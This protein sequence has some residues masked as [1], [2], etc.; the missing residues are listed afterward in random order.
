MLK[1]IMVNHKDFK[2]GEIR[3]LLSLL[4]I[5]RATSDSEWKNI[6]YTLYDINRYDLFLEFSQ[7]SPVKRSEQQIKEQFYNNLTQH[8]ISV[9]NLRK[10]L[11]QDIGTEEY[12]KLKNK[13]N[14]GRNHNKMRVIPLTEID[15]TI[16]MNFN[17]EYCFNDFL[18]EITDAQVE[19]I[20]LYITK[21]RQVIAYIAQI[22]GSVFIIKLRDI[23]NYIKYD[24][25]KCNDVYNDVSNLKHNFKVLYIN[26]NGEKCWGI[27][28]IKDLIQKNLK[29]MIK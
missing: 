5:N 9:N 12:Q 21:L 18:R 15:M 19:D 13:W 10:W 8:L 17:D 20:N 3:E 24:I 2:E 11:Q 4:N 23:D 25:R 28:T 26:K 7:R 16:N 22:G 1:Y 27:E 14:T 6:G 29:C